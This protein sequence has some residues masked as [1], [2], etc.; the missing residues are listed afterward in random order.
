MRSMVCV[1]AKIRIIMKDVVKIHKDRAN[2]QVRPYGIQ[3]N[4]LTNQ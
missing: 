4:K 1:S 3:K 2:T